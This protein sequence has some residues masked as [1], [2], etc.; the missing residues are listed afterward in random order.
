M[1]KPLIGRKPTLR[2]YV[3]YRNGVPLGRAGSLLNMLYRSFGAVSFPEFWQFW[4]PI[5]GYYL[6]Y[7]IYTPLKKRLSSATALLITFAI[8]GA[9]H[10]LAVMAVKRKPVFFFTPWFFLMG[11]TVILT[12]RLNITYG[13]LTWSARASINTLLVAGNLVL[14]MLIQK[15]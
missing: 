1:D 7:F 8:S 9:L 5:W 2:E 13:S 11:L 6:G 12:K 10:D 15:V 4:N 3:R 14:A